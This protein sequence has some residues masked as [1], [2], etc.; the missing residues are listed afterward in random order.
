GL[1]AKLLEIE[2]RNLVVKIDVLEARRNA[3]TDV[4][5]RDR[6]PL[7]DIPEDLLELTGAEL[8]KLKE[9]LCDLPLDACPPKDI[10]EL[11]DGEHELCFADALTASP[12]K[13]LIKR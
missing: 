4:F 10:R 12:G 3:P 11:A 9:L 13:G 6:R 2:V 7:A 8:R 1:I 5:S